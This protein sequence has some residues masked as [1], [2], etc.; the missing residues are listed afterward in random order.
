MVY[1]RCSSDNWILTARNWDTLTYR[2]GKLL[3]FVRTA[4]ADLQLLQP[5]GYCRMDSK[6]RSWW[7]IL[8]E[9]ENTICY[10]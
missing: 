3:G 10:N 5:R 2:R 1:R 9:E 8:K 6:V 7:G 4:V